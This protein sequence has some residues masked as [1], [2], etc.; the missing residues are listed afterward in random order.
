LAKLPLCESDLADLRASGLTEPTIRANQV[1]TEDDPVKLATILNRLPDRPPK[2][3]PAFCCGGGMVFPYRNLTGEVNCFA[4]VKPHQPRVRHGKPIKYEQPLGS[5][6]HAYFP[7]GSLAQLRAGAGDVYLTEGEKKTLSLSQLGLAAVG[8]GGVF[9]ALKKGTGELIDDLAAVPWD[10]RNVIIAFDSDTEAKT[11]KLVALAARRLG[12]ALRAAGARQVIVIDLPPGPNGAKMGA[13]DYIVSCGAEAFFALVEAARQKYAGKPRI[14]VSTQEHEVNEAAVS[15]LATEA[16]VYQRGGLLV[17]VVSDTSPAAEGR[18]IRRPFTPR[19]E[20]LPA[21]ILRERLAANA[22][23]VDE[24]GRWLHPPGWCVAAVGVRGD[25]SGIRHLEAI[26]DHPVLRPDGTVLST[27][28]YDAGTGL[29]LVSNG[30]LRIDIPEAPTRD[31]AIA[32]RDALFEVISDFPFRGRV[33]RSAWLAALLT[34]VARFAFPGPSPLFLVEGNAPAVGKGLLLHITSTIVTGDRFTIATYTQDEDELR[35]RITSLAVAGDRLVLFDNLAGRF[36]CAT[37]DAALTGTVWEDRLLGSNRM[38]RVPLYTTWFATGNNVN[39]GGDTPRRVCHI[40]L[41]SDLEKPEERRDFRHPDLLAYVKAE[42]PRLLAAALTILRAYCRA[43]RPDMELSPWGSFE[44]W[45]AL[46]RAAVVWLGEPDPGESRLSLQRSGE[47]KA[48]AM[49]LLMHCWEKMDPDRRG[50]TAA[51]V[52]HRLGKEP[53]TEPPNDPYYAD[54][55]GAVETLVGKADSRLLGYYLRT[56]RRR[57]IDGKYFDHAGE[58]HKVMR[59]TVYPAEFF[60][61]ETSPLS[62]LSPPPVVPEGGDRGDT[63]PRAKARAIPRG[64]DNGER[65]DVSPGEKIAR[66]V[67]GG[68]NGDKSPPPTAGAKSSGLADRLRQFSAG[69]K[70]SPPSPSSPLLAEEKGGQR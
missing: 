5:T 6:L 11:R 16:G 4:R 56:Y 67:S 8:L 54:M 28:G 18:G 27:P 34:P 15:A 53:W 14:V 58:E 7:V 60:S 70:I 20:V 38:A 63:S 61:A 39:I 42:R 65:G 37:L 2:Q 23:W 45:T 32:A 59:W 57:I 66:R 51:A 48:E 46:V 64:G 55:R 22:L 31:D 47:E 69:G 26:V 29:L 1:R 44:G 50:L 21:P 19:I 30:G 36:G 3:I 40:R 9:C 35:K 52:M 13:D 12:K 17:R 68:D 43:G 10:G 49:R 24:E 41:E 33:G 62:P 25:W